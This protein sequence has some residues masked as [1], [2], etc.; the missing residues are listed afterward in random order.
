MMLGVIDCFIVELT[1][2]TG[3]SALQTASYVSLPINCSSDHAT[4]SLM[5][6]SKNSAKSD[7]RSLCVY[8]Y[9]MC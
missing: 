6:I 5:N 8:L 7:A 4:A 9:S 1:N 2:Y 3:F